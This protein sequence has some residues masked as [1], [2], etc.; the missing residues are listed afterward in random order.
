MTF[1]MKEE[2]VNQWTFRWAN[3]TFKVKSMNLMKMK[4][5]I[6]FPFLSYF[7]VNKILV[8]MHII[9]NIKA[10]YITKI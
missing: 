9:K 1:K 5:Y 10:K 2:F 3:F 6:V 8:M 4:I 7:T